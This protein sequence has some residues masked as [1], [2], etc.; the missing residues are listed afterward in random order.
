[1]K[2]I[3]LL[4]MLTVA[5]LSSVSGY[6]Y[7]PLVREGQ[8]WNHS[9][10]CY[11]GGEM[12]RTPHQMNFDTPVELYGKTYYPV[13]EGDTVWAYMRQYGNKVYLLVD[14]VNISWISYVTEDFN[15]FDLSV[16]DEIV[17][18]DFGAKPGDKYYSTS[19]YPLGLPNHFCTFSEMAPVVI[20]EVDTIIV[21]G[22][23]RIRQ[24]VIADDWLERTF[25]EGIGINTGFFYLPN[26]VFITGNDYWV[27]FDNV[28]DTNGNIIFSAEDFNAPAYDVGVPEVDF[29]TDNTPPTNNKMYDLNGREIHNPLPG[30]VYILNGEKHVAK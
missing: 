5:V 4:V 6:A 10:V 15:R 13:M 1:M 22:V 23:K 16:G 3:R 18:Y 21:N 27:E 19:L 28:T 11:Y 7:E 30:T 25:V 14:G 2:A 8:V 12:F 20:K 26:Y 17:I 24:R 9:V 29:D